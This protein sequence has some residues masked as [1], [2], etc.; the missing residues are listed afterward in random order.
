[1]RVVRYAVASRGEPK[2]A[3]ELLATKVEPGWDGTRIFLDAS[4]ALAHAPRALTIR[5]IGDPYVE[6][7]LAALG[8]ALVAG[9]S[10]DAAA[11]AL[12]QAAVPDGR[13]Q[14]IAHERG[15]RVVVDYAHTPDALERTLAVARALCPGTLWVVFGAGGDRDPN[16][17]A[18]MGLAASRADRVVLTSDNPRSESAAHI[19]DQIREGIATGVDVRVELDRRRAIRTA[20]EA[21]DEDDVVVIAGKGHEAEQ[22][23]GDRVLPLHDAVEASD[24]LGA[25]SR[26]GGDV[27]DRTEKR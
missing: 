10:P 12:A 15:P 24:A 20:I 22:I 6:N 26:R 19:C 13:F 17:R 1:V 23:I 14:L 11:Q 21:A 5:G 9:V 3:P 18:P 25:R 8:A 27:A 16:K 4:G 2:G 7:A